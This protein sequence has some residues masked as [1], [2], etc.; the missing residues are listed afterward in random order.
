MQVILLF[1]NTAQNNTAS[2][3]CMSLM[4]KKFSPFKVKCTT[5]QMSIISL[6]FQGEEYMRNVGGT[7]SAIP[8]GII[9]GDR[10]GA[11]GWRVHIFIIQV[12]LPS[13]VNHGLY[14]G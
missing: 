10:C 9:M 12:C 4:K 1:I 14:P 2:L 11:W 6:Y 5:A 8:P 3:V 7:I 13:S